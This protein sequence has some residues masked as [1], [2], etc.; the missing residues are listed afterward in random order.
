VLTFSVGGGSSAHA[1][2]QDMRGRR[3][4]L[5]AACS[6]LRVLA[7]KRCA[8][9][10]LCDLIGHALKKRL[11]LYLKQFSAAYSVHSLPRLRGRDREGACNKIDGRCKKHSCAHAHPLP[12]PQPK[13]DLSDFGR[14][15]AWPNPGKP[16]FGCKRGREQTEVAA[17]GNFT[18]QEHAL[19]QNRLCLKAVSAAANERAVSDGRRR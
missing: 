15:I 10:D 16:E 1:G 12:N 2:M 5:A 13:S 19:I 11:R 18:P 6:R 17:C 9:R 4:A 3:A 14:S 8:T 7:Q